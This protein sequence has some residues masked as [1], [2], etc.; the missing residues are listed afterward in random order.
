MFSLPCARGLRKN[1]ITCCQAA[2]VADLAA[3]FFDT[4]LLRATVAA[5]ESSAL[6]PWS[7][8]SLVLRRAAAD[9]PSGKNFC[10]RRNRYHQAIALLHKRQAQ[11][12]ARR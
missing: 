12:Y 8:A 3:E 5:R 7:A 11:K 4:E 2:A 10:R 6:G 9:D 1:I